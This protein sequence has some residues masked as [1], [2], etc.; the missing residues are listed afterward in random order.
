MQSAAS[1]RHRVRFQSSA[2]ASGPPA[3]PRSCASR[4]AP[5]TW[6]NSRYSVARGS[7]VTR[8]VCWYAFKVIVQPFLFEVEEFAAGDKGSVVR[9]GHHIATDV[10]T[11]G[12][13]L[14]VLDG[15]HEFRHAEREV[16]V[17]L[18]AAFRI[19][20]HHH[21]REVDAARGSVGF[22]GLHDVLL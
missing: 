1:V 22:L 16:I 14:T 19:E 10:D 20:I 4:S 6:P 17:V 21:D 7:S 9:A 5:V 12:K 11:C 18:L 3:M 8:C 2:S 13:D 15:A